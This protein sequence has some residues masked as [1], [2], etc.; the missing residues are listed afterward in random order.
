MDW[1]VVLG[2]PKERIL[3]LLGPLGASGRGGE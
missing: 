3:G 1:W 2:T